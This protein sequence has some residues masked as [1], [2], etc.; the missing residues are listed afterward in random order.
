MRDLLRRK[1]ID[2]LAAPVPR[3]TRRDVRLPHFPRKAVAVIGMRRSGKT[4]RLWQVVADRMAAGVPREALLYFS[5]EDE[6]LAGMTAA[7]LH[8]LEEE[9]FRVHPGM[10]GRAVFLL[11]EI[12]VVPGWE[13]FARRLLDAGEVELFLSGSSA[14][15][16][17]REVATSMRGRA[18]AA[19]VFPFSFREYLRHLGRE[20]GKPFDRL[21]ARDRSSVEKDLRSYLLC[22]GFPETIGAPDRDRVDLLR[23]YVD[24]ALFRDVVERHA[25]SHPVALRWMVRHLLG[26]A[27]GPFT[28]HRFHGDLH[29]QGIPVGKDTLHAY[30]AH[31]EDAFIV[32]T[33]SMETGSERKRMVNPRKVYSVDPGLIPVYDRTGRANIGHALETAVMVELE[34]RGAEATWVRTAEGHEVDFLARY[35]GG[36]EEL[37]QVCAEFDAPETREREFRALLEGKKEHPRASRLVVR[38]ESDAIRGVPAGVEVLPAAEWLLGSSVR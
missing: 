38:L 36:R 6:L 12:Q 8:I 33:V 21:P 26:N 35:H 9:Y 24:T 30:L 25:V 11:D 17:S 4:T 14:R 7:E 10:R 28:V 31:L 37:I 34:R 27:A 22:G 3:F 23:T 13:T 5:F 18:L 15:L 16:L 19:V 20:P 2:A 32:R 1:I 29:S